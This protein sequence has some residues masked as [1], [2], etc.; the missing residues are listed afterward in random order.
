MPSLVEL[1]EREFEMI[2]LI[3]DFFSGKPELTAKIESFSSANYALATA[4]SEYFNVPT[5][6]AM[7][8]FEELKE[9]ISDAKC[10]KIEVFKPVTEV[11]ALSG[12]EL[13]MLRIL[14]DYFSESPKMIP[15]GHY[16]A[17]EKDVLIDRYRWFFGG[18]VEE[19]SEIL[20]QLIDQ[21]SRCEFSC[22]G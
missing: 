9:K 20:E 13:D 1:S 14:V 8:A 21:F 15:G 11:K 5:E 10:I 22:A 19:A 7:K 17:S 4:F 2:K 12:K 6:D 3:A 18:T 16:L